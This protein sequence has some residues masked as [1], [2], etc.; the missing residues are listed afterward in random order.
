MPELDMRV[1]MTIF[2]TGTGYE[3]VSITVSFLGFMEV[4]PGI[5]YTTQI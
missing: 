3:D 1:V 5:I 4:I 2:Y